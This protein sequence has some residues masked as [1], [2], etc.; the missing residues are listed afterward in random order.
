MMTASRAVELSHA[1][2]Q[3]DAHYRHMTIPEPSQ[4]PSL[5]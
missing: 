5:A 4:P 1:L 3:G 2:I